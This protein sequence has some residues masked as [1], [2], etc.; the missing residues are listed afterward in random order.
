MLLGVGKIR[1]QRGK[2]M[3]EKPLINALSRRERQIMD[4]VYQMGKATAVDVENNLP[5]PPG[6]ATVRKILGKLENKGF[7]KHARDGKRFVY[8][9]TIPADKARTTAIDH[10]VDTFFRGSAAS[11][12]V[13][14][15]DRSKTSLT[16]DDMAMILALVEQSRKEGR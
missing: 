7:L 6:N 1:Q 12:V 14:L 8:A 4:I 11:A 10:L 16:E 15:L 13:A 2:E 9:P 3:T 5:D